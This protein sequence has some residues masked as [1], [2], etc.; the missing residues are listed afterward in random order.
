MVTGRASYH[1][2]RLAKTILLGSCPY[3][4]PLLAGRRLLEVHFYRHRTKTIS[5]LFTETYRLLLRDDS[6]KSTIGFATPPTAGS[7]KTCHERLTAWPRAER[8]CSRCTRFAASRITICE[9][10]SLRSGIHL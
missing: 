9:Q 8:G 6:R 7:T 4:A 10:K 2:R 3:R 5:A 1:P